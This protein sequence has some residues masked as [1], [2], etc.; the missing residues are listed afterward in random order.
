MRYERNM[1]SMLTPPLNVLSITAGLIYTLYG[2]CTCSRG[3]KQ[4]DSST[5]SVGSPWIKILKEFRLHYMQSERNC[6]QAADDLKEK[7][8]NRIYQQESTEKLDI[9]VTG[10]ISD[11]VLR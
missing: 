5:T 9:S 3:K 2:I 1:L 11:V 8:F 7:F 4:S 6:F 10:F